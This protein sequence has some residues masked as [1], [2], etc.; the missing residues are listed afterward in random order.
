MEEWG[1]QEIGSSAQ[2]TEEI[3]GGRCHCESRRGFVCVRKRG[4]GGGERTLQSPH[5]A[6]CALKNPLNGT[7][8]S[9]GHTETTLKPKCQ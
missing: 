2:Y 9:E 8:L 5:S 7:A 3:I 1:Q 4:R 6:S